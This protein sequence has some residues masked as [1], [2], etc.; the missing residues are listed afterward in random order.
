[1][2][3]PINGGTGRF[4]YASGELTMTATQTPVLRN[5]TNAPALLPIVGRFEGTIFRAEPEND[6]R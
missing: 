5:A 4:A 1:V 2:N 3:Y 6:D